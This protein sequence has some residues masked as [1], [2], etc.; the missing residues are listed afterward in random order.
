MSY[1]QQTYVSNPW[2]VRDSE[3]Q[4]LLKEFTPTTSTPTQLPISNLNKTLTRVTRNRPDDISGYQ[5]QALYVLPSDGVDAN[6]DTN[7]TISTSVTVFQKWFV[8]QTG[9]QRLKLDTYEGALDITFVRL[10]ETDAQIKSNGSNIRDRIE[11]LLKT[12]GFND[13]RKV[14]AVYYGGGN[15][16]TCGDGPWPPTLVGNV[17]VLYLNGTPPGV[18]GC[19]TNRFATTTVSQPG[20]LEFA[21]IHEIIHTLGFVASCAP[22]HTRSGHVSDSPQDLMYAGSQPWQP[23][24]L[25][26][27]RNDYFNHNNPGC[28]DLAESIFLDPTDNNAVI[29]PGWNP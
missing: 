27:G 7:G 25:D 22:N 6:L 2:V 9:G 12:L 5:I 4:W 13:K 19:N 20:Y 28:L 29:P 17:G 24:I 11:A 23:S 14:Y 26:V 3:K 1:T 16:S 15:P 18:A 8:G 21:M 10:V